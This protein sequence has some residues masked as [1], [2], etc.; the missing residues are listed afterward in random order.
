M[1]AVTIDAAWQLHKDDCLGSLREGKKADLVIVSDNPYK[2]IT[3]KKDKC[4][5]RHVHEVMKENIRRTRITLIERFRVT[6]TAN[7][8]RQIQVNNFSK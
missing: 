6:L 8:K 5:S 2:V 4:L 3:V 1:K 7:S